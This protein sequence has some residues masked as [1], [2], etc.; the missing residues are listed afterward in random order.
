MPRTREKFTLIKSRR[1]NG[2]GSETMTEEDNE[3]DREGLDESE[4]KRKRCLTKKEAIAVAIGFAIV[5]VAILLF[6]VIAVATSESQRSGTS[7]E[8]S[9]SP[10]L[11][12]RLPTS[13]VP[14][15]YT[16]QLQV[17]LKALSVTGISLIDVMVGTATQHLI[18]HA[19]DMSISVNSVKQNDNSI[20]IQK[21]FQYVPND[22]YVI[23]LSQEIT[24]RVIVDLNYNYSLSS[25]LSGFYNSS[26][27]LSSGEKRTLACTQFEP[28][29]ARKAFPCFD[30]P[31]MKANFTISI[32][33]DSKLKAVS[34][35]PGKTISSKRESNMMKTEFATSVQMSTYLVA[36]IVSDF[37]NVTGRTESGLQIRLK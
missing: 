29:D 25:D 22:Y 19:K 20:P 27:V 5:L 10:W 28:T 26:F 33:H 18:V 15:H 1:D 37:V 36:F 12:K 7:V 9:G 17:D 13:T 6:I 32:V 3:I 21:T 8:D 30:E 4:S 35:M 31:D 16:V 24:G 34:N 11:N 23:E 2:Q 14:V